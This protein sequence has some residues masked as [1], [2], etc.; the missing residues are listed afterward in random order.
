M[1]HL[2]NKSNFFSLFKQCSEF[3]THQMC[4]TESMAD[5]QHGPQESKSPCGPAC[6]AWPCH[7]G[8]PL[9]QHSSTTW[10]S[11]WRKCP[12]WP[13]HSE[14]MRQEYHDLLQPGAKATSSFSHQQAMLLMFSVPSHIQPL[15]CPVPS[16][17]YF[18]FGLSFMFWPWIIAKAASFS[19]TG[20]LDCSIYLLLRLFWF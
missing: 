15:L 9:G 7:W 8:A 19:L 2:E 13:H 10:T 6:A 12:C 4:W 3:S 14:A 17:H 16:P 5:L 1:I 18:L 11:L 20:A